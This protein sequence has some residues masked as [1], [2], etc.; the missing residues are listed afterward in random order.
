MTLRASYVPTKYQ[1]SAVTAADLAQVLNAPEP[2]CNLYLAAAKGIAPYDEIKIGRYYPRDRYDPS[3]PPTVLKARVSIRDS[4][5]RFALQTSP[6]E[7]YVTL[8]AICRDPEWDTLASVQ[9][10][11]WVLVVREY[12][13]VKQFWGATTTVVPLGQ[14]ADTLAG[15]LSNTSPNPLPY[16]RTAHNGHGGH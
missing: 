2:V 4:N 5:Y 9:H 7:G 16:L 8:A 1:L 6:D 12:C 11:A 10:V 3:I 14:A 15:L 13:Q